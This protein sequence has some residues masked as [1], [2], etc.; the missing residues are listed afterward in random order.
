ML[1]RQKRLLEVYEYVRSKMGIHTQTDF[2]NMIG[3]S[4]AVVSSAMNGNEQYLTDNLF[5][6]ICN[7][8]PGVF[9]IDYLLTGDGTLLLAPS[10]SNNNITVPA[11]NMPKEHTD[12]KDSLIKMQQD[13]IETLKSILVDKEAKI[14]E[15]ESELQFLKYRADRKT[16]R[17]PEVSETGFTVNEPD[18]K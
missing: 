2:G 9:N 8:Y 15:L 13:Y 3:S 6:K 12:V 16:E 14:A 7:A 11:E 10:N 1:D 18:N 5:H 4:R 17:Y